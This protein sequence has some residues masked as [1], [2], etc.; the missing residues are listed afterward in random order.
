MET[1]HGYTYQIELIDGY[2]HWTLN[3][4]DGATLTSYDE[5]GSP[6]FNGKD[7]HGQAVQS[8]KAKIIQLELRGF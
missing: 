8:V 3:V 5:P 1:Y 6:R 7:T 2:W 4:G